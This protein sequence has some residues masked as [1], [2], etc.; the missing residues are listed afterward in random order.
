VRLPRLRDALLGAVDADH[1]EAERGEPPRHCAVAATHVDDRQRASGESRRRERL[2]HRGQDVVVRAS[3]M[4]IG[5][6]EPGGVARQVGH[7]ESG[8]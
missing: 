1:V 7:V 3:E 5:V 4:R 8:G 6:R 2:H